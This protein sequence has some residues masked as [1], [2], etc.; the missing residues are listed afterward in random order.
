MFRL[1]RKLHFFKL[2]ED[3]SVQDYNREFT[4]IVNASAAVGDPLNNQDQVSH[5]MASLPESYDVL[6]TLKE[7][8]ES[9][10]DIDA[11]TEIL[12]QM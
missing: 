3:G 6:V 2:K 8:N 7:N 1:K 5:L 4:E 11:V 12:L 9:M 10:P